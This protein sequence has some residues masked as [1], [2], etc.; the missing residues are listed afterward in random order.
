MF[1][2]IASDQQPAV[3]LVTHAEEDEYRGLGLLRRRLKLGIW[4]YSRADNSSGQTDLNVM[5]TAIETV[6]SKAVDNPS[7]NSVTLGGLVYWIRIEGKLLL[8][9]GDID[10]Q[11]L[12]I[13][14][15]VCEMP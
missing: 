8:D 1:N 10:N 15:L 11:T 4:I 7:S 5:L 14:P 12:M 9:P 2:S 13:I 6:L 3:F